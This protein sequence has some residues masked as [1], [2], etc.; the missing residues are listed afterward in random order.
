M[1]SPT[2]SK[3]RIT[4]RVCLASSGLELW[5][6]REL[7]GIG[8]PIYA[9]IPTESKPDSDLKLKEL[10]VAYGRL[11]DPSLPAVL[12]ITQNPAFLVLECPSGPSLQELME[13]PA[14]LREGWVLEGCRQVLGFF[15][16]LRDA[17]WHHGFLSPENCR[18][19]DGSSRSE[20]D[21]RIILPP[22][23]IPPGTL[24]NSEVEDSDRV[25]L[26]RILRCFANIA[27]AIQTVTKP[28]PTDTQP[29]PPTGP[30]IA[31]AI[32]SLARRLDGGAGN[33][34]PIDPSLA[35]AEIRQLIRNQHQLRVSQPK[36]QPPKSANQTPFNPAEIDEET[37]DLLA[38]MVRRE[39]LQLKA[40][41]WFAR[42]TRHP[43]FVV[44][45]FLVTVSVL[46]FLLLPTS[47]AELYQRGS[48]LMDSDNPDE[49]Q[50]GWD[51]YLSPLES[52]FPDQAH[53]D[54][55]DEY[56]ERIRRM[57]DRKTTDREARFFQGLAESQRQFLEGIHL[58]Q[59]GMVQEAKV[60]WQKV[61]D[62][63]DGVPEALP[64]VQLAREALGEKLGIQASKSPEKLPS[65]FL[66]ALDKIH[67][68]IRQGK[69]SS[70]KAR[71]D[72]LRQLHKEDPVLLEKMKN[73]SLPKGP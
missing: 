3:W 34:K 11:D 9:I 68:E 64:W 60:K 24:S 54:S 31:G 69:T 56:R 5:H 58:F 1:G 66:G 71:L 45:M 35:L 26:A 44:P 46:V 37:S 62:C 19:R 27:S 4:E 23:L 49:W 55:M 13:N 73:I 38:K 12:D 61:I 29:L 8:S 30:D 65:D 36:V 40:G 15:T 67:S 10:G 7:K 53:R 43:A 17:G 41:G 14:G 25:G 16:N 50:R 57:R 21:L 48:A 18:I 32:R 72:A 22:P 70:A 52:R 42:L 33:G 59:T 2:E 20:E 28:L 47:A 51:M 39:M 6:G 63:Y